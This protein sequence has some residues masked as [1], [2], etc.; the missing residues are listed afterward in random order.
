MIQTLIF[1][2][3]RSAYEGILCSAYHI[4]LF[5]PKEAEIGR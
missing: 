1:P 3:L 5:R 4:A 2:K